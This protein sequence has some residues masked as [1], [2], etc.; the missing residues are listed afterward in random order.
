MMENVRVALEVPLSVCIKVAIYHTFE[1]T[2]SACSTFNANALA[3]FEKSNA[4]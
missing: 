3:K 2:C 4:L 1:N